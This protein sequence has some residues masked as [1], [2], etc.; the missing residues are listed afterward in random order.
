[1]AEWNPHRDR[2]RA[3]S[4]TPCWTTRTHTHT[5][6]HTLGLWRWGHFPTGQST[7]CHTGYTGVTVG[8]GSLSFP[9]FS[10]CTVRILRYFEEIKFKQQQN[11][12]SNIERLL[13]KIIKIHHAICLIY[14]YKEHTQSLN[15]QNKKSVKNEEQTIL[16]QRT[17]ISKNE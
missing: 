1:M 2:A 12:T 17:F 4:S 13:T 10:H 6:K 11:T 5:H 9:S 15:L 3:K 8:G 7:C 16:K 14:N